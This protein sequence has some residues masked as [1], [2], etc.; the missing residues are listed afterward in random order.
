MTAYKRTSTLQS[1][2]RDLD[3]FTRELVERYAHPL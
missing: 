3:P 2:A 1:E